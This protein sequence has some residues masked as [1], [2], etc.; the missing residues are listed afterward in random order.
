R[1][2]TSFEEVE[3][4]LLHLEDLCG[5]CE[6]ERHR[7]AQSQHLENYRKSKSHWSPRD[8]AAAFPCSLDKKTSPC[9]PNNHWC[10]KS[11]LYR[12]GI[13]IGAER[14]DQR[15]LSLPPLAKKTIPGD[16]N[17]HWIHKPTLHQLGTATP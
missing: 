4:H 9:D 3:N 10:H 17:N 16:T 5:R 6:L 12:L 1:L 13:A 15:P 7:H 14:T 11:T 8:Q 2:E